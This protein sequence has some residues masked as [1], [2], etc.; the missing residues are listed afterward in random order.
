MFE[1]A[2]VKL[3]L[4]YVAIVMAISVS[5]SIV[6]YSIA[7]HEI[8]RGLHWQSERIIDRFPGLVER[9]P[10]LVAPPETDPS[11]QRLLGRL[12]VLN[13][14]MLAGSGLAS[15]WLARRTLEP[16]EQAHRQQ[17]R[18]TSDVSHELRTPL[19][20]IRMQSEVALL[21]QKAKSK[22]LRD[23][24]GSNLEEVTK[25]EDMINNL[26]RLSRLE[27]D[28][29]QRG[30]A[31]VDSQAVVS[32]A[33]QQLEPLASE[34]NI[35]INTVG[36]K[37]ASL[38]GDEASL[39]QLVVIL[40]DNAIKFSPAGETIHITATAKKG[41][42]EL[43]IKDSGPGIAKADLAHIF[44]RFYQAD[45]ARAQQGSGLG[46]SIAQ[47]IADLHEGNVTIKSQPGSGTTA[48]VTLPLE[49]SV[50]AR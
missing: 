22:A 6:I 19:T 8:D 26:L 32:A 40:L 36:I 50:P 18:F 3:T 16:I 13:L 7:T 34:K 30:F 28:E 2:T 27:A 45:T 41:S 42:Y 20:A 15:Y 25:L 44:D 29:I 43:R 14:L 11:N 10:R 21:N 38:H 49:S 31:S 23:V 5:F 48:I 12:I 37:H 46:L 35:T 17:K 4:W 1:S 33:I 9:N 39:I 24:I 47:N